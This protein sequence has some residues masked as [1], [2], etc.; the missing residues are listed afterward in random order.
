MLGG[1]PGVALGVARVGVE[2]GR[3]VELG[4]V[5]EQ[6]HHDEVAVLARAAHQRQVTVVERAHRR[7]EPDPAAGAP[8][9]EQLRA[10]LGDGADRVHA[11][12]TSRSRVG[13][14]CSGRVDQR[15][16]QRQQVGR[17]LLD[18]GALAFDGGLVAPRHRSGQR[19]L[20][21]EPRPV[22]DRGAHQR[23]ELRALDPGRA[24]DPL[25]RR[26]ERD[27][28]VRRDRRRRVVRG[29]VS[30]GDLDRAHAERVRDLA[31]EI[32][33]SR[34]AAGDRRARAGEIGPVRGH[35][36]QRMQRERLV[37]RELAQAS[38][39]RA[40]AY[41][42]SR[43]DVGGRASDLGVGHAQQYRIGGGP[44]G[45]AT[46]RPGHLMAGAVERSREGGTQ[47]SA[48]DD[49]QAAT[50]RGVRGRFPFQFPHLRYRSA[51]KGKFWV[52]GPPA[53]PA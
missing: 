15:V 39:S 25:G 52:R 24:G 9:L 51:A 11:G 48:A 1:E 49:R 33:R 32:Q 3:V 12:W 47:P 21:P 42:R 16:E 37:R 2:V 22:L 4:R 50:R 19:P 23:H 8:G 31:R 35:G 20:G 38:R 26:L 10:Q 43:R 53:M 36:H 30:L 14:E 45:T 6:R 44:V 40:V 34:G 18:R 46:E 41:K 29:A 5:H 13:C 7:D 27:Q 17:H 28:E